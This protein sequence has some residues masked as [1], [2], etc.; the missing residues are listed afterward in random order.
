MMRWNQDPRSRLIQEEPARPTR[1][2]VIRA[3][4]IASVGAR[5]LLAAGQPAT[6]AADW[7]C[8]AVW[9]LGGNRE[10]PN[11]G[12]KIAVW[13]DG[14]ILF[15]PRLERVGEHMLVGAAE[16]ADV[17]EM[18]KAVRLAGFFEAQ[19]DYVVPDSSFT[20]IAVRDGEG[21]SVHSFHA[22]LLPGFGGDI[23]TDAKYETVA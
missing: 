3:A 6:Q 9:H 23:N 12:L 15:S 18:L 4:A 14:T 2:H 7:P 1:R 8:L 10:K 20:T 22:Y 17:E 21:S 13:P 16:K 11:S 5:T 19:R